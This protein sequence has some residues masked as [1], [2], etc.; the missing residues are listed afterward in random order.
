MFEGADRK[1]QDA[2]TAIQR[3]NSMIKK[4]ME[5]NIKIKSVPLELEAIYLELM[6]RLLFQ[7][8]SVRV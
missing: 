4:P 3:L 7:S 2:R 8:V 1:L 5:T 6:I